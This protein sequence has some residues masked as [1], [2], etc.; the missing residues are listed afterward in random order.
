M[1]CILARTSIETRFVTVPT[2]RIAD[3]KCANI[4][5]SEL[6][7]FMKYGA[8]A[9]NM[10]LEM[11][12]LEELEARLRCVPCPKHSYSQQEKDRVFQP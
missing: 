1:A 11:S 12:E 10:F 7:R 6:K 9:R 5:T 8:A 3:W 2:E 4:H